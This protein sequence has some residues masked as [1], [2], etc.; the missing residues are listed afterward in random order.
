[1]YTC[2][3]VSFICYEGNVYYSMPLFAHATNVLIQNVILKRII[4][5]FNS[6]VT[7]AVLANF[8]YDMT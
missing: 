4:I 7:N 6:K 2:N 1:M 8:K 3:S 5:L